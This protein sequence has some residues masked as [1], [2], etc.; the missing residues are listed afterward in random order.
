[1]T[2]FTLM[3]ADDECL[4]Q[5]QSHWFSNVPIFALNTLNHDSKSESLLLVILLCSQCTYSDVDINTA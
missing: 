1:M 3:P 4:H 2:G 5:D